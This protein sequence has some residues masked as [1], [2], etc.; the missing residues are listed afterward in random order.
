MPACLLWAV[1]ELKCER[2][3]D[4][5]VWPAPSFSSGAI[6]TECHPWAVVVTPQGLD[7][8]QLEVGL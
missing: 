4:S 2:R 3:Y 1:E 6:E 8:W 5:T 7:R